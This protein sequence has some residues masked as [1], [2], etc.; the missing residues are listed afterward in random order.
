MPVSPA[1]HHLVP[2]AHAGWEFPI[3]H[4]G[5]GRGSG[6]P[7]PLM[8]P[9]KG[10]RAA[11]LPWWGRRA[12]CGDQQH[13]RG[14]TWNHPCCFWP[15]GWGISS[16]PSLPIPHPW[17]HHQRCCTGP[18]TAEKSTPP[19][20]PEATGAVLGWSQAGVARPLSPSFG[21]KNR[22]FLGLC[23]LVPV[24]APG[25]VLQGPGCGGQ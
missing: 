23:L 10:N 3:L 21:W 11:L 18:G 4:D 22:L 15:S 13:F 16:V 6:P 2:T 9:W 14:R 24:G 20:H 12:E 5:G 19:L 7:I 8:P 1:S 17:W 25:E